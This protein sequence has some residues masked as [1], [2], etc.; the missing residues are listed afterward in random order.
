MGE[1]AREKEKERV[2]TL[3]SKRGELRESEGAIERERE[4]INKKSL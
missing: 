1:R 2:I 3:Y 4:K